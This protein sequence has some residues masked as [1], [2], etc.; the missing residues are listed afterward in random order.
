MLAFNQARGS[1]G[2]AETII[3]TSTL[4]SAGGQTVLITNAPDE[5]MSLV[6][7]SRLFAIPDGCSQLKIA[8]TARR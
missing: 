7:P 5:L 2:K 3:S 8:G 1:P 6:M 4:L